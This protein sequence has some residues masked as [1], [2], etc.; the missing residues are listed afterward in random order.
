M[1]RRGSWPGGDGEKEEGSTRRVAR[2]WVCWAV[3]M[4]L[5][6]LREEGVMREEIDCPS[7]S[8]LGGGCQHGD[9]WW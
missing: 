8:Y 1:G 5:A 2:S 6:A 3:E 9:A 7:P 4:T